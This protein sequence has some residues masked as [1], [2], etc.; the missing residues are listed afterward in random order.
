MPIVV[1]QFTDREL[2]LRAIDLSKKCVSEPN[3]ILRHA[4]RS[5]VTCL[6]PISLESIYS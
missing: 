3:K 5:N 6:S 1:E 4:Q 2:M